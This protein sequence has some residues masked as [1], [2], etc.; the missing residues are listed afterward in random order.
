MRKRKTWR[1]NGA[2]ENVEMAEEAVAAR[3]KGKGLEGVFSQQRKELKLA[4][5]L[6]K[7]VSVTKDVE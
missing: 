3:K 2:F 1:A 5:H 4:E 6:R 7:S